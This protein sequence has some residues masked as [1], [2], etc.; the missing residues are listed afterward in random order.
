MKRQASPGV[1]SCLLFGQNPGCLGDV[2]QDP[3][4]VGLTACLNLGIIPHF[5]L[6]S[7]YSLHSTP[8]PLLSLLFACSVACD[9]THRVY[10]QSHDLFEL[11]S[12]PFP[13]PMGWPG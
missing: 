4:P 3:A 11:I 10:L 13:A 6:H 12:D 2:F 1:E 9:P 7:L 5:C 8:A